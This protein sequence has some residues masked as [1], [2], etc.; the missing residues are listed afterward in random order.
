M[1]RRNFLKGALAVGAVAALPALPT[2]QP[3]PVFVREEI[4]TGTSIVIVESQPA[5]VI[6]PLV[7]W[8]SDTIEA[9][10][11]DVQQ[12][13]QAGIIS[14][15]AALEMLG[16]DPESTSSFSSYLREAYAPMLARYIDQQ[17][18]LFPLGNALTRRKYGVSPV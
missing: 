9:Q 5:P 11:V 4:P 18:V 14:T 15:D 3:M 17:S 2:V 1:D 7:D 6:N 16:V 12:L 10:L 13:Q 8:E